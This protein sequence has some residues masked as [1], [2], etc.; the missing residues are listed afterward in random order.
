ME[1]TSSAVKAREAIEQ[2]R[3]GG[4]DVGFVPTMGALH[5]GHL[6]LLAEARAD[7]SFLAASIFV[8]PLQFGP[9]EDLAAYPRPLEADI[10]AAGAAGCDL[11]FA[12]GEDEMYPGGSPEVTVDPGP[13]GER[14]EGA[15]RPGHFRG[16][17]TVVAKLFNIVGPCRAY[18]GQ[19]DAQQLSLVS[20]MVRD[21]HFPVVV[22]G[23][24]TVREPDGLALSSRNA[25]LSPEGRA[26]APVLFEALSDAATL[27]R[28]GERRADVVRAEMART[29]G[30]A[31]PVKLDYVA[32]VDEE[33]WKDATEIAGPARALVAARIGPARLIDNILLPWEQEGNVQN[34]S[35]ENSEE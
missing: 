7:S 31:P 14:L 15:S 34:R 3:A 16:V 28:T 8:N 29:I 30:S 12:P 20:R 4:A 5:R 33:T 25:Y 22:V 24:P 10:E 19:K 26:A 27:V 17:L 21:L 1:V 11:L 35:S 13:V 18:F 6:R 9:A 32:V 2:A 23:V